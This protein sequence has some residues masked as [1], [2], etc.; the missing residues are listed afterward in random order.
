MTRILPLL[1]LLLLVSCS[2]EDRPLTGTWKNGDNNT[3]EFSGDSTAVMGMDGLEARVQGAYRLRED[4]VYVWSEK[5]QVEGVEVYNEYVFEYKNDS[6][7]LVSIA[8]Y[9]GGDMQ[10]L[11]AGELAER[12]GKSARQLAFVKLE[13]EK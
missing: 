5:E 8:L 11:Y 2:P 6:L 13:K 10:R 1:I 7:F 9:R 12:L 3:L 4:T